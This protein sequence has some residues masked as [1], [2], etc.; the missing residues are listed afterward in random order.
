MKHPHVYP[1][2]AALL[3]AYKATG[4][5]LGID[6]HLRIAQLAETLPDDTDFKALKHFVAPIIVGSPQQQAD[7][8]AAFD[9]TL[10]QF[11]FTKDPSVSDG[12]KWKKWGKWGV[13]V[14]SVVLAIWLIKKCQK[15]IADTQNSSTIFKRIVDID[16]DYQGKTEPIDS[17]LGLQYLSVPLKVKNFSFKEIHENEVKKHH[18]ISKYLDLS[19]DSLRKTL[20]YKPIS[21]GEDTFKVKF[22][23]SN[24]SCF[25]QIHVFSVQKNTQQSGSTGGGWGNRFVEKKYE[26]T[27]DLSSLTIIQRT[28]Y[29]L[30]NAYL[31]GRKWAVLG[32]TALV[33]WVL[34]LSFQRLKKQKQRQKE[35]EQ[36][37]ANIE[38][39]PNVAPPFVHQI[40]IEDVE[41]VNFDT[42]FSR[43]T[44]ELRHRSEI[45]QQIF[46]PKRTI[47]ATIL[48]GG[49][50]TFRY[51]QP[52]RA[53]EYLFLIDIHNANDHRAQV[54]DLL[55]R[56][57]E[58]SEVVIERFFYDGDLRLCWNDK[59][60]NG[61]KINELAHRFGDSRLVIVGTAASL[62]D[63]T[64]GKITD[65]TSVFDAWR[66]RAL[67]TPRAP[68]EWKVSERTLA[69]K[70]RI[71]PA[72]LKG[73]AALSDTLEAID[74]PDFRRW[75]AVVDPNFESIVLPE[76]LSAAAIMANLEAEFIVYKNG[77]ADDRLLQWLAACA[78]SPILHWDMTLFFGNLM[79]TLNPKSSGEPPLLSLDNLFKIN[80][81]AW[82]VAGKMPES[83]RRALLGFLEK[84]DPSVLATV[85]ASWDAVLKENMD[86]AQ[87]AAVEI[88]ENFSASVA[89]DD[90]RLQMIVNDLKREN[91]A[92]ADRQNLV[93]ELRN[94]SKN[95]KKGDFIALEILKKETD[96]QAD[97]KDKSRDN[98]L[99]FIKQ[100][101]HERIEIGEIDGV[102]NELL[103][104]TKNNTSLQGRLKEMKIE[105]AEVQGTMQ[106]QVKNERRRV[107]K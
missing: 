87:K 80:R 7:F 11:D 31:S 37:A 68:S 107:K 66:Q 75:R 27:P 56:T 25:E 12:Q 59:N 89:F 49:L 61:L 24:D 28:E 90:L 104:L 40:R 9:R 79:D 41:K 32:L 73:L 54:F 67:L 55:H 83:A 42:I 65:W 20:F 64:T 100:N 4:K 2:I 10:A 86:A 44:Q 6:A 33:L 21:I 30:K 70:F 29:S 3:A 38:R 78:V 1:F 52:T 39:K 53:H 17:F 98:D 35:A 47:K 8:Y 101:L 77:K 13:L 36:N 43:I 84:K 22:C 88:N 62:I 23:L 96:K 18:F 99:E 103:T 48:R 58:R 69:T 105:L 94:L 15:P 76:S 92:E 57:L 50:A 72:N 19:I 16:G 26:H 82:F 14:L 102:I 93:S 97:N 95:G 91:I 60:R 74:P 71:L 51:R 106:G 63:A 46:D 34:G 85:R 81:L 5:P 45:E